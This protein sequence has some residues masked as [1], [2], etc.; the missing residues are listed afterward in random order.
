VSVRTAERGSVT[1]VAAGVLAVCGLLALASA[2]VA[3]ALTA[4]SRAQTAADAAALAAAHALVSP[5]GG[6]PTAQAAA[7]ADRNGGTLEACS[8]APGSTEAVVT[9]SVPAGPFLLLPGPDAITRR[10]RAVIGGATG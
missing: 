4:A 8:C 3:R 7:Y 5:S 1:V 10:A 2:D 6:D 9:V